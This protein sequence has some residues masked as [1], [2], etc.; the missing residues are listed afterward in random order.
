MSDGNGGFASAQVTVTVSAVPDPP[1]AVD[2]V[3]NTLEDTAVTVDV[4]VNDSDVDLDVLAVDSV[5]QG[6]ERFGG[7]QRDRM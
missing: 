7:E 4:L 6:V 1:V 2:D 3:D 5:T